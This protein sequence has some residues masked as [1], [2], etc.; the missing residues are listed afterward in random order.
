MVV[1]EIDGADEDKC[2]KYEVVIV[3]RIMRRS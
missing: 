3:V 2:D 1:T